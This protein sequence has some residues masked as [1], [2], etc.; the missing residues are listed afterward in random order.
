MPDRLLVAGVADVEDGIALAA[1]HLH[2][3]VHLGDQRADRVHDHAV[4]GAGGVHHRGGRAVRAQ[5]ERRALGD[6][7]D[8]VDEDHALGAEA[9]DH[10]PVVHD[11]VVA[12][13]GRLEDPHHPGQGLDR[14][15]DPGAE[16][17]GL[18]KH[19]AVDCGHKVQVIGGN[20]VP[21][22]STHGDFGHRGVAGCPGRPGR[23]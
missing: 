19:D 18:G 8:V 2:L 16:A 5:H 12:V 7:G 13:D 9:L 23:G 17:S 15:F 4:A 20:L 3:V 10:V 21:H 22:V 6:V 11:L 1:A 14:L